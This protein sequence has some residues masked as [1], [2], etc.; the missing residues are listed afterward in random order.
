MAGTPDFLL[1][2]LGVNEALQT[3]T[4]SAVRNIPGVEF[5]SVSVR[6]ADQTLQ[7]VA[8]TDD[9][10][11]RLDE[12]QYELREG[13]CYAAVTDERFILVNDLQRSTDFPAYGPRAVQLGVRAQ[14]ATQVAHNGTQAG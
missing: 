5:A 4:K 14:L 13:P 3:I 1:A 6:R 9:L 10:A 2:R 8:A 11:D 7:T 12:I